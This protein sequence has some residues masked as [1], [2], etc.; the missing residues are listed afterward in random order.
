MIKK[1]I[2]SKCKIKHNTRKESQGNMTK[3]YRL[4]HLI[5]T[6]TLFTLFIT[7]AGLTCYAAND[8]PGAGRLSG[9]NIPAEFYGDDANKPAKIARYGSFDTTSPFTNSAYSHQD[10]F[11]G[12]RIAHGIDVSQWQ[13]NIDW[14]A[15]KAAGIEF[16]FVRV[17]YRGYGDA[18]TLNES[19]KDIYFDRNM[20][21]ANA[22]GVPVGI[23]IFSQAT[24]TDEAVEEANYILQHIGTT[25]V[26]SMPLIMDYEYA[27]D[28]S[29]GG[30]IKKAKLSKA[31]ATEVC[32]AFCDTIAAAGYTPMVYANKSMLN[33]QLNPQTI[34]DAGYR[35]WL[36]HYTTNTD[37]AG[38]F[39]FWQYSSTG[40]VGG[41]SGNVDMNFYYAQ[42]GDN[43]IPVGLPIA[44]AAITPI[45]NQIYT[46]KNITPPVS[47]SYNGVPLTEG[48]DYT[49]QYANNKN[50]GTATITITGINQFSGTAT[51]QFQILPKAVSS[52]KAKKRSSTYITLKWTKNTQAKGYQ[53]WR[54]T[55]LNGTYKK[56]KQISSGSTCTYKNTGLT[57]GQ[58]YYY[59]VRSF[60]KSGSK[61]YYSDF[62]PV[63]I[64]Y[65]NLGYSR[66]AIAKNG[67]TL[68]AS[69]SKEDTPV[70]TPDAGTSM[71]V[72]YNT[73]DDDGTTW[74]HVSYNAG[75]QTY[76]GYVPASKVTINMTGKV[77]NTKI[78]NVRKSAKISSKR[79]TTLKKNKKVTVLKTKTKKG[80]TWYQVT[81]KKSGK[82]YKGWIASPYLKLQ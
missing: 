58:G 68:Y 38:T 79:L 12:R 56:I 35:I 8:D 7:S 40:K 33:S 26:V 45:A 6:I 5:S 77:A 43:F 69:E 63:A 75:G 11:A 24:T 15:V 2:H 80:V 46:G 37:Y 47:I 65:T 31:Q 48:I 18:G 62:S 30:R 20:Q 72:S 51:L 32:M 71:N 1:I 42:E 78:V 67:T 82:T 16:A 52:V 39:D 64:L 19:T 22:A 73:K 60:M 17:G 4:L 49:L 9:R 10:I 36:A 44:T 50:F 66:K 14:T 59:K 25:H 29:G 21:N 55:S 76:T 70:S 13:N 81:F 57:A 53:I 61:T 74:Y 28:D 34:T 27:S 23:Y 54:S 3:H 41:I